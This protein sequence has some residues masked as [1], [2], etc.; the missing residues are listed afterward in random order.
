MPVALQVAIQP[1]A[2]GFV[3]EDLETFIGL[4]WGAVSWPCVCE[5]SIFFDIKYKVV[6]VWLTFSGIVEET[7]LFFLQCMHVVVVVWCRMC[8]FNLM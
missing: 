1:D 3:P 8:C 6:T 7:I 2:K 4:Y 5:A